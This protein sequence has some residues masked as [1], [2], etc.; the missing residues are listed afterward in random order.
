MTQEKIIDIIDTMV[1]YR[2]IDPVRALYDKKYLVESV[3]L[4]IEAANIAR[5][6]MHMEP[7]F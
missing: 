3:L 2:L 7:L 5:E 1:E 6:M 4:Y